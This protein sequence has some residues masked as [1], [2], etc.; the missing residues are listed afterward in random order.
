MSFMQGQLV[1]DVVAGLED[2]RSAGAEVGSVL[3]GGGSDSSSPVRDLHGGGVVEPQRSLASN[4]HVFPFHSAHSD[5]GDRLL[6]HLLLGA[7]LSV[8]LAD[9]MF[10]RRCSE[11][12][13]GVDLSGSVSVSEVDT[14]VLGSGGVSFRDDL[15]LE[16]LALAGLE[17]VESSVEFPESAGSTRIGI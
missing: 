14:V 17:L 15:H 12:L 3:L 6:G 1:S 7:H 10:E 2:G 4:L 16:D 5:D 9:G 11:L 13:E 8:E